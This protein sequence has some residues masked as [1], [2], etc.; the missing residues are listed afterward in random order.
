MHSLGND[1]QV[2][3]L[4]SLNYCFRIYIVCQHMFGPKETVKSIS[5]ENTS[6]ACVCAPAHVVCV[7]VHTPI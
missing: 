4:D 1:T 3:S 6:C 5:T 2:F 7:C